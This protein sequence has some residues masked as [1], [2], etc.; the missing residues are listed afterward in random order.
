MSSLF[1]RISLS[2]T[3]DSSRRRA[4]KGSS[5]EI[6]L[7]INSGRFKNLCSALDCSIFLSLRNSTKDEPELSAG[8][9][10]PVG[11]R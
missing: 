7:S 10:W 8:Y 5:D 1:C 6:S 2:I 4:D 9:S 11:V 3:W